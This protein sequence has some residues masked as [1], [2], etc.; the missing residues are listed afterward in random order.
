MKRKEDDDGSDEDGS[1][2]IPTEGSAI[3]NLPDI[4]SADQ[5]Q[6]HTSGVDEDQQQTIKFQNEE[7]EDSE[8]SESDSH[9][10]PV[11]TMDCIIPCHICKSHMH[12]ATS[13]HIPRLYEKGKICFYCKEEGSTQLATITRIHPGNQVTCPVFDLITE[14]EE[15]RR[16][17]ASY[18]KPI[19]SYQLHNILNNT[20][21]NQENVQPNAS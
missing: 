12:T 8:S 11:P 18:M 21:A 3:A 9:S 20:S 2:E 13:C 17:H 1:P 4:S 15:V 5:E 6:I 16:V 7:K 10:S 19:S 14:D